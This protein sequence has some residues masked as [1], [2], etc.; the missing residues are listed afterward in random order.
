MNVIALTNSCNF[1]LVSN[2]DWKRLSK[3]HWCQDEGRARMTTKIN[4]KHLRMHQL[5]RK[6]EVIH[7]RNE[8]GLDNRREN[9]KATNQGWHYHH[10]CSGEKNAAKR[11]EIRALMSAVAMGK[12]VGEKNAAHKLTAEQVSAVRAQ[13]ATGLWT[14]K[15]LGAKYKVCY[16]TIHWI[17]SGKHWKEVN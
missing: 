5:I 3:Y 1:V 10:H 16:T 4:G 15:Q 2:Q 14:L 17:V 12:H 6:G 13:Y 8:D 9:L 7:H 11:P